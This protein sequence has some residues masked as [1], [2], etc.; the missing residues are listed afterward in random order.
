MRAANSAR[1]PQ[2][3]M[4][5]LDLEA[6]VLHRNLQ[7]TLL[8]RFTALWGRLPLVH[9]LSRIALSTEEV[10]VSFLLPQ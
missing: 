1:S 2:L 3:G 5:D 8:T 10:G 6:F 9:I 7:E 4:T